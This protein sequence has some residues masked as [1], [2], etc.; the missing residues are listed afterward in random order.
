MLAAFFVFYILSWMSIK[1]ISTKTN[2][3]K[4]LGSKDSIIKELII[5]TISAI[6]SLILVIV[7]NLIT[8]AIKSPY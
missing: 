5:I 4:F 7:F 8:Q 6:I 3:L 1:L 2:N